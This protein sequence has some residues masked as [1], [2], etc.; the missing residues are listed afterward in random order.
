MF[1]L[2]CSNI[3]CNNV[4]LTEQILGIQYIVQILR[5]IHIH[6]PFQFRNSLN[7]GLLQ[8][9]TYNVIWVKDLD[10]YSTAIQN[11]I[12]GTGEWNRISI[13]VELVP[14]QNWFSVLK[15]IM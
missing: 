12:A 3:T 5:H 7:A 4:T 9:Y 6:I 11:Q 8:F 10:T 14:I 13:N 2:K 1:V 15:P